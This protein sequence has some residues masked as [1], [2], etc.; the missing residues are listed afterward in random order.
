MSPQMITTC[1][2][3]A[4]QSKPAYDSM[5]LEASTPGHGAAIPPKGQLKKLKYN[6]LRTLEKEHG[7]KAI[8]PGNEI[9]ERLLKRRAEV[10][11]EDNL[12]DHDKNVEVADSNSASGSGSASK[13]NPGA[14]PQVP[15]VRKRKADEMDPD[16]DTPILSLKKR[17]LADS[18]ADAPPPPVPSPMPLSSS[19]PPSP[20]AK[21]VTHW[22]P[23]PPGATSTLIIDGRHPIFYIGLHLDPGPWPSPLKPIFDWTIGAATESTEK[24]YNWVPDGD[25][26]TEE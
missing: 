11:L 18:N 10:R 5:V 16:N 2:P 12:D 4:Q 14:M 9:L 3:E 19:L 13:E 8:G 25:T 26:D 20:P 15:A 22:I 1:A 6:T 21:A 17:I 7:L 23:L 24:I